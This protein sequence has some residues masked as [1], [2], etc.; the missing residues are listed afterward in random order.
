MKYILLIIAISFSGLAL[1]DT[2]K[3]ELATLIDPQPTQKGQPIDAGGGYKNCFYKTVLGE[4]QFGDSHYEFKITTKDVFCPYTVY[5]NP[6]T[7]QY[8][9]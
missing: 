4:G 6:E 5:V 1:A 3:W 8:K 2:D 9:K 7:G